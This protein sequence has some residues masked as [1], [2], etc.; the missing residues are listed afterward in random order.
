MADAP[1]HVVTGA[2]GYTG[3][4]LAEK[5]LAD[6][7]R[8]RTLTN[9]PQRKNPFGD[10]VEA[11]PF[12]FDRPERL[13]ESLRGAAVLYNTYWVRFDKVGFSHDAAV[14]RTRT[15]FRAAAEAK[16]GRVVHVSI[17]SPSESSPLPYFRGKALLERALVESGLPHSIVR[18][19]V[20]FGGEDILVNNIAWVLRRFPVFGVFGD[21]RYRLQPIHVEDFAAL[22]Q[23]EGRATGNRVIDAVGPEAFTYRELVAAIGRAIGKKRPIVSVPPRLGYVVG[24][25]VGKLVGDVT[26]TWEEVQGLMAGLLYTGAPPAGST[27]LTDWARASAKTLGTRYHS[28]LARRRDRTRAYAE[29]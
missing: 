28:E 9:S 20:L 17:T 21:G 27:R 23:N 2:F 26:I 1:L 25:V 19:A 13:V 12:D 14:D 18:P 7:I 10:Q 3:R 11:R 29:M 16:V 8:V 5:L 22:L 15:L 6:G 24:L 4:Y